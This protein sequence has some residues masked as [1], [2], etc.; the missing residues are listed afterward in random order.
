[1]DA[2]GEHYAKW[3]KP[4]RERGSCLSERPVSSWNATPSSWPPTL[5]LTGSVLGAHH[6]CLCTA[7]MRKEEMGGPLQL[8]QPQSLSEFHDASC[9][10]PVTL[11][12]KFLNI[13]PTSGEN[14]FLLKYNL[15]IRESRHILFY[16]FYS[17]G[18]LQNLRS[19]SDTVSCF[20][21]LW[22]IYSP[23]IIFSAVQCSWRLADEFNSVHCL[24]Q[25][26]DFLQ[27]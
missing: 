25:Q 21:M 16:T 24:D 22:L 11:H 7:H 9:L 19:I 3:N 10:R 5:T 18:I 12:L 23:S 2:S 26:N 6:D 1:M 8:L 13:A 15:D 27:M 14:F 17:A 4:E 20:L